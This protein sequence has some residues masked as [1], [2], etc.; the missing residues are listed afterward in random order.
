MK[1]LIILSAQLLV[2][3]NLSLAQ[4]GQRVLEYVGDSAHGYYYG[5]FYIRNDHYSKDFDAYIAFKRGPL[6]IK[7]EPLSNQY[8]R[9]STLD[10]GSP[11]EMRT[12]TNNKKALA[13]G[14][15]SSD[16]LTMNDL[17][18]HGVMA[19]NGNAVFDIYSTLAN[20]IMH[21]DPD[22]QGNKNHIIMFDSAL[23]KKWELSD[24]RLND[25]FPEKLLCDKSDNIYIV[26]GSGYQNYADCEHR[27]CPIGE[28]FLTISADIFIMPVPGAVFHNFSRIAMRAGIYFNI[29]V[30]DA[31]R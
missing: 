8:H 26:F 1:K 28:V 29:L 15:K 3:V 20:P 25:L 24:P 7:T 2:I 6:D 11:T 13:I 23:N 30:K 12:P 14:Y 9:Y 31:I 4:I 21:N 19:S 5:G 27:I 18:V 17:A 16:S 10:R 22:Y